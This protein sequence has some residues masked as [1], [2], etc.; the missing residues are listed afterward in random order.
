M[1][2]ILHVIE[3]LRNNS[4]SHPITPGLNVSKPGLSGLVLF[5]KELSPILSQVYASLVPSLNNMHIIKSLKKSLPSEFIGV[6]LRVETD[7]LST[8]DKFN[9][10]LPRIVDYILNHKCLYTYKY[11]NATISQPVMYLASGIFTA[12]YSVNEA[13]QDIEELQ[14]RADCVMKEFKSRG[15]YNIRTYDSIMSSIRKKKLDQSIKHKRYSEQLALIDLYVLKDSRCFIPAVNESSLSYLVQRF[16][17]FDVGDYSGTYLEQ[18]VH[19]KV[20]RHWGF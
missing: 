18:N 19:T 14:Y 15:Y 11:N 5:S 7:V 9:Q 2:S 3:L 17:S 1:H 12:K 13:S 6:H 4:L 8:R 10:V 20:F 16:K